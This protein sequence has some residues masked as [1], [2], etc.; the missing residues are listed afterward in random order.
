[1]SISFSE[2][3]DAKFGQYINTKLAFVATFLMILSTTGFN[4]DIYSYYSGL[5]VESKISMVFIVL[6]ALIAFMFVYFNDKL[7]QLRNQCVGLNTP[8]TEIA[9]NNEG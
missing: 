6:M 3:I 4:T 5:E 2:W 1:M 9:D 8:P 7:N